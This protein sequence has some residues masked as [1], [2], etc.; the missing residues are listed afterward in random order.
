MNI[1]QTKRSIKTFPSRKSIY[2]MSKHGMGKSSVVSQ[3]AA[4]LSFGMKKFFGFID[5]RLS[6]KADVGDLVGVPNRYSEF[7]VK[8]TGFNDGIIATEPKI[9]KNCTVFDLPTWFPTDPDSSGIL[10]FDELP[11][12]SKEVLQAIMEVANDY[13]F[14][15]TP[16]PIGWRVVAAGN[17]NQDCYGGTSINPALYDRFFKILFDPKVEEAVSYWKTIG[18]HPAIIKYVHNFPINCDPPDD[19]QA[20][21]TYPSRRSWVSL[22]EVI[23]SIKKT[24]GVDLL[25]DRSPEQADY[26]TE[27]AKGYIGDVGL[28]FVDYATKDY[29][30]YKAEDFLDGWSE[31]L[32]SEVAKMDA[33]EF[34]YYSNEIIDHIKKA[35]KLTPKQGHN[36]AL[37]VYTIPKEC[38][39]GFWVQFAKE[40]RETAIKWYTTEPAPKTGQLPVEKYLWSNLY[41]ELAIA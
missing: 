2:P 3:C 29:K 12:G 6:Q 38:A 14:N 34:Y 5:C 7:T 4:E 36:L 30:V 22:S 40:V 23:Q 8:M 19:P 20:G 27:V 33:S 32:E 11:Y 28:N 15:F 24:E 25:T 13:R 21:I 10:F 18:V 35:G 17:H 41:K 16:L 9:I 26:M 37:Y 1:I 39:S 31:H